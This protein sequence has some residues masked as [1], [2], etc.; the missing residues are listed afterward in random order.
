MELVRRFVGLTG[1]ELDAA[2]AAGELAADADQADAPSL[3]VLFDGPLP[4]DADALAAGLRALSPASASARVEVD[5]NS[6][7][8]PFGIAGWGPHA[9]TL[10][11]FDTP[12]PD[13]LLARCVRPAHYGASLKTRAA[14]HRSHLGLTEAG[15]AED[16]RERYVAVAAVAAVAARAGGIVVL[17]D[18]ARSS[19]PAGV[20]DI[21]PGEGDGL[22]LLRGL[23][24]PML[25][26]GFVKLELEGMSG[27]WMRTF[28]AR[29]L[30]LPDLATHAAGHD[31]GELVFDVFSGVLDYLRDGP[32][33]AAGDTLA[34]GTDLTY[35]L[36]RPGDLEYFLKTDGDLFVLEPVP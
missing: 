7:G 11:G 6:A 26:C 23:P 12:A 18:A 24:L 20:L 27:V 33:V 28:G 21:G 35:R 1:P 29:L 34:L 13:S 25:Y 16:P 3:V 22:V 2:R 9:V 8:T 10:C 5:H 31:D 17:N 32:D 36:R 19:V 4:L 30:G 15:A 14:A